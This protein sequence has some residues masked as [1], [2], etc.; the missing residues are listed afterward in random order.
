MQIYDKYS[1]QSCYNG[2]SNKTR[3]VIKQKKK[4]NKQKA[5]T[6][7]IIKDCTKNN[8]ILSFLPPSFYLL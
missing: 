8:G 7:K 1:V 2:S 6:T 3:V 5:N 4:D